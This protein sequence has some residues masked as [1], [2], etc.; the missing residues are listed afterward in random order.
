MVPAFLDF[1]ALDWGG[2]GF[3]YA[4]KE[5]HMAGL[6]VSAILILLSVISWS[7]MFSKL[8][9]VGKASRQNYRFIY[10]F[11]KA[12]TPLGPY[13]ANLNVPG[14]PIFYVYR[15]ACN[16]LA[17]HVLGSTQSADTPVEMD[18][19][20]MITPAQMDA[21]R[22]SMDRAIGEMTLHLESR[23]TGLA[24]AVSGAPF[25]GLLGT[26]WGV[27]ETFGGVAGGGASASLQTMAPG[28][29]AA[30]VTTVIALL[31]AIP[32][33]FGYN[34]LINK[35]RTLIMEMHNYGAELSTHFER[36]FVDF[37]PQVMVN[38]QV[39]QQQA[40]AAAGVAYPGP[41]EDVA[42]PSMSAMGAAVVPALEE[43]TRW[44]PEALAAEAFTR[45]YGKPSEKPHDE[46]GVPI[47]P[48]AHQMT[49]KRPEA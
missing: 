41:M 47:N 49:S 20:E 10:A 4:L 32:A 13:E 18:S 21:V 36:Q 38:Q 3:S 31:V 33:M 5:S 45:P 40:P 44:R 22:G 48:I 9:M 19:D 46:Y 12:K 37:G 39:V 16:E 1:D 34:F 17:Y 35:I 14:S 11:R 7:V 8:G 25:L 15:A 42:P 27:M 30:L 29:A 24:T 2:R 26:V 28:V 43:T 23:M 6:I